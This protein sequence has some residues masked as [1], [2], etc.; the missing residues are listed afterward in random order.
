ME[1]GCELEPG[2]RVN[3]GAASRQHVEAKK[4]KTFTFALAYMEMNQ[5]DPSL[6]QRFSHRHNAEHAA[7]W[8]NRSDRSLAMLARWE[9]VVRP[10]ES[11]GVFG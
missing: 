6:R 5:R 10:H 11:S 8:I 4:F 3:P 2:G 9:A 7:N 1:P